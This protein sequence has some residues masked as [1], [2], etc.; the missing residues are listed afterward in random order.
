VGEGDSEKIQLPFDVDV[1]ENLD[2][3][4][5][6]IDIELQESASESRKK[7]LESVLTSWAE[8]GIEEGYGGQFMDDF[9]EE[10]NEWDMEGRRFRFWV[11]AHNSDKAIDA[12]YPLLAKSNDIVRVSLGSRLVD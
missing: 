3:G 1:D 7:T 8:K 5:L 11:D 10:E 6:T 4:D 2:L 9:N 12:L